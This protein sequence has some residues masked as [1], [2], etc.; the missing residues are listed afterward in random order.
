MAIRLSGLAS[1]M[2]TEAIVGALMSAQ[3]LKKTKISNA[4]TKLEWKQDKW[5]E[6]NTKLYKLYTEQASKMR[7][8]SSYKTKKASVSN[9]NVAQVSASANAANGSYTMEVKNIATSQYLTSAKLA[10]AKNASQKLVEVDSSLLNA[11]FDIK[12]GDKTSQFVVTSETTISDFTTALSKAGLNAN[13]DETQQRFFLS[14]KESGLANAFSITSTK[15][16]DAQVQT[17]SDLKKAV[18]YSNMSSADKAVVDEALKSLTNTTEGSEEYETALENLAKVKSTNDATTFYKA[19]IYA[20]NYDEVFSKAEESLQSTYYEKDDDGNLTVKESLKEKYKTQYQAFTEEDKK[21]VLTEMG[22]DPDTDTLTEE[23]YIGFA[24]KKEYDAA[25]S[26]KADSDTVTI[27]NKAVS[28]A[29]GKVEIEALAR[30]G[31]SEENLLAL[32]N[33]DSDTAT[34]S[35]RAKTVA[36]AKYYDYGNDTSTTPI[37]GFDGMDDYSGSGFAELKTAV[38]N[39]VNVSERYDT[40]YGSALDKLGMAEIVAGADGVTVN[41]ASGDSTTTYS[42]GMAFVAAS[43]SKILLNGAELTSG[44]STVS[45]NGLSINLTSTTKPGETVTFAVS[46]DVDAVYKSIKDALTEYNALIKEMNGLYNASSAKGYEPLSSEEKEAMTE[47]DVKLY[48]DKIKSSLLRSD[49]SLSSVMNSMKSAM[50][51]QIEYD[52]KKY[53]LASFGIMTSRD[54]TEGGQYHIYGDSEDSVYADQKDKLKTALE[55][56]PEKVMA[57][58]SGVFGQLRNNMYDKMSATKVS[59]ALTFYNDIKMK[60]DIDNYTSELKDWEEKL[61]DMED[62]YYSQFTAMEKALA[63]LQ[64]QQTSLSSLFSS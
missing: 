1:G 37:T 10:N 18:G 28:S 61:E 58:L 8:Q 20:K 55:N 50:Q 16:S 3:S 40:S 9:E 12:V 15:Q 4:K 7:L 32:K 11:Q 19:Q 13:F 56:E 57:V 24:A 26:K 25:V 64:S 45:A 38:Q 14:S 51:T 47:E 2:D 5:K 52:G 17:T 46:N 63:K 44:S 23:D 29:E 59:S 21:V 39:Y 62:A 60:S 31:V 33:S 35:D 6:L 41:G 27:V 42:S 53:S 54:F 43:D 49:S 48:E 36:L 22:K 34:Y 30:T